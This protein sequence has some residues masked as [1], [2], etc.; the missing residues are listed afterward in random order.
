MIR[1]RLPSLL[2]SLSAT[3]STV[4]VMTLCVIAGIGV[5]A[6]HVLP[7]AMIP[8]A[9]E[10]GELNTGERHEGVFYSLV[11]LM[12][13]VASSVAI[14][15]TAFVL[16]LTDYVPNSSAQPQSALNGIRLLMGPIPAV[17]LI[18]GIVFALRY[19]LE[20]KEFN[21]ILDKLKKQRDFK[22]QDIQ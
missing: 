6:A 1:R 10:Y 7:W 14:P 2:M 15:L 5:S 13:K 21:I 18:I 20:R 3:S 8:D 16:E 17:L 11:T 12:A 19:P 22:N 4:W 9:I